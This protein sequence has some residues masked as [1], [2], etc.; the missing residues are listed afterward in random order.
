MKRIRRN[1]LFAVVVDVKRCMMGIWDIQEEIQHRVGGCCVRAWKRKI[2]KK[3]QLHMN[4]VKTRAV[5]INHHSVCFFFFTK[6]CLHRVDDVSEAV[7]V[8]CVGAAAAVKARVDT[9]HGIV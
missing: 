7:S 4:A 5:R 1:F 3:K 8:E 6:S 2:K 9:K